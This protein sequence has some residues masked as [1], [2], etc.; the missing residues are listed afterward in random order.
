[1]V[2]NTPGSGV[3]APTAPGWELRVL[4]GF[5]LANQ[6][7]TEVPVFGKLDR[8]L[9]AY[10]ALN[11]KQR[12]PRAKLAALLWPDR[13]KALR[14]LSVSL[15]ILRQALGDK[16]GSFIGRGSDPVLCHF[17]SI[18]VDALAFQDLVAQ[19]TPEALE[20]AEALYAGDL[21]DGID[22]RSDEFD[23]W[24]IAERLRL[25]GAA[26]DGLCRLMRH[27]EQARLSQKAFDTARRVLRIDELCQEAHRTIVRLHLKAGQRAAARTQAQYCELLLR[28][29]DI[30]PEAETARL[31]AECRQ[32][33]APN[34]H[35]SEPTHPAEG[36]GAEPALPPTQDKPA[37][38]TRFR[39][40]A[41]WVRLSIVLGLIVI[42]LLSP[43]SY[44]CWRYWNVPWLAPDPIHNAIVWM[45][46][47]LPTNTQPR[48]AILPFA[49]SG[50][51]PVP[52]A[53]AG[54]S[55]EIG[56]ALG[57]VSEM[58]VVNAA[59]AADGRSSDPRQIADGLGV[60]Y[61]LLGSVQ[62]SGDD[63]RV[64]VQLIDAIA[65][66]EIW[67]ASYPGLISDL[68]GF[69]FR[70]AITLDV[71]TELQVKLTVGYQERLTV[72]RLNE[73]RGT[74]N[75]PAYLA[76]GEALKLL[77]HVTP[78]D[79]ARARNLYRRAIGLDQGYAGAYEGLAWTH[80]LDAEFGWSPSTSQSMAEAQRLTEQALQ[81]DPEKPRLYSLRGHLN[82]L[83]REFKSAVGDGER[84]VETERNDADAA[85]LLA[86]TLTYTNDPTRAKTLLDR[87]M[88]LS[89][90]Y[91]AWYGWALGRA[92][93]LSGDPDRAIEALERNL[94]ERPTSIV[95]L[96][97][98]VIAYDSALD[99]SK[100]QR[101]AAAIRERV[102][103]FSV[104]AWAALQPYEDPAMTEQD[105]SALRRAGLPD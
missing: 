63:L 84:A 65:G 80:L 82:L 36:K 25:Q 20:Q 34:S 48:I 88:D 26:V 79:N 92:Y 72:E 69:G 5:R 60:R 14:S 40:T 98:L 32:T 91:P 49:S 77:R 21:L 13:T 46:V 55:N 1:M 59:S 6:A 45:K 18:D 3:S 22:I 87:A 9:L 100:A 61:L 56:S 29:E 11:Q 50:D 28:R 33:G 52:E 68:Q 44:Q 10:L 64:A 71:V 31:I 15:N 35:P 85:A 103:N 12:H 30:P 99:S 16:N 101:M 41:R 2:E 97:E 4:G 74:R 54:V 24:L 105:A 86:F 95:P 90:R 23:R 8:A 81:L 27:H 51:G 75:L 38:R 104:T 17:E 42:L 62:K 96:V 78:E 67:G 39:F 66:R 7:G 89:P 73:I 102:P 37:P 70:D 47:L 53:L 83:Y 19:E 94:P 58:F 76:T 93:R 57:T 43:L